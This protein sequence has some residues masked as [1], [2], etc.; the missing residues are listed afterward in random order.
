MGEPPGRVTPRGAANRDRQPRRVRA[1]AA[2]PVVLACRHTKYL[3]KL[4]A[5]EVRYRKQESLKIIQREDSE[6]KTSIAWDSTE[7]SFKRLSFN[8]I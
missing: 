3:V 2:V 7:T 5:R 1:P 6:S 4:G 8:Q